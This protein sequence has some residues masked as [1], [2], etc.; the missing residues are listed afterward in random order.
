MTRRE[1]VQAVAEVFRDDS[2]IDRYLLWDSSAHCFH[3]AAERPAVSAFA[4]SYVDIPP[5]PSDCTQ[6]EAEHWA[7]RL[8]RELEKGLEAPRR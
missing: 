8:V 7:E 4:P 5:V 6:A 2:R 3:I 1:A